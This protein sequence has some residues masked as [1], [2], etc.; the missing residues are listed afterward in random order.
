MFGL[1]GGVGRPPPGTVP[2]GEPPG[3]MGGGVLVETPAGG[4]GIP[5]PGGKVPMPP[6][7]PD[8]KP[9]APPGRPPPGMGMVTPP[10]SIVALVLEPGTP[11]N[12]GTPPDTPGTA[13]TPPGTGAGTPA[14]DWVNPISSHKAAKAPFLLGK[15]V[16]FISVALC[17]VNRIGR[18]FQPIPA[19]FELFTAIGAPKRRSLAI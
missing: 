7:T 18:F 16:F 1:I 2:G 17:Q 19:K 8:G 5:P 12:P 4:V 9:G 11:G 15:I 3:I 6:G 13:G 10:G 14:C